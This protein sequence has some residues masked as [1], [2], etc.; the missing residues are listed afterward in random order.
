MTWI[1]WITFA[2]A[3]GPTLAYPL[4]VYDNERSCRSEAFVSAVM[5]KQITPQLFPKM[6]DARVRAFCQATAKV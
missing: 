3:D 2:F 4:E 5:Y 6:P 1:L